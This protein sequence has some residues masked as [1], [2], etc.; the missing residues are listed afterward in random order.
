MLDARREENQCPY[1]F[2]ANRKG[3][4]RQRSRPVPP[5]AFPVY[6][7]FVQLAKP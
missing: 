5:N 7:G 4:Y 3:S 6:F 2:S 1:C